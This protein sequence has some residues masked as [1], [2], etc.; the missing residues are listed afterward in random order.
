MFG[1]SEGEVEWAVRVVIADNKASAKGRGAWTLDGKMIDAPVVGKA[2]SV[3]EKAGPC[4]FDIEAIMAKWA[5]EE[6]E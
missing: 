6:P 3:V 4:G 2:R 5:H 1:P